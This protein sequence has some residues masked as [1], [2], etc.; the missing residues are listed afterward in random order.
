MR[1]LPNWQWLSV[2]DGGMGGRS[3][4]DFFCGGSGQSGRRRGEEEGE[5]VCVCMVCVCVSE[6]NVYVLS[7]MRVAVVCTELCLAQ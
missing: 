3:G 6:T 7:E 2:V 4:L 5:Y 1:I